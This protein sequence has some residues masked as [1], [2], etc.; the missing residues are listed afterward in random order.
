MA[1][2]VD[3]VLTKPLSSVVRPVCF[4]RPEMSMPDAPSTA[5]RMGNS[6]RPPG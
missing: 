1:E 4:V 5:G 2:R 3:A 6:T